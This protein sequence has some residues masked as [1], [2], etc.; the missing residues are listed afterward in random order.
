[1]IRFLNA[2]RSPVGRLWLCM[3]TVVAGC[4]SH[5]ELLEQAPITAPPVARQIETPQ[6]CEPPDQGALSATLPF[7]VDVDNPPN[8]TEW[9]LTLDEVVQITLANSDVIRDLGGRVVTAPQAAPTVYDPA[10]QEINPVTGVEAA[11]SAFDAQLS[12]SLFLDRDERAFNNFFI[13]GG[14][15]QLHINNSNFTLELAKRGATGTRYAVRNLTDRTSNNSPANAF[16]S[17]YDTV[18]EA[19]VRHPLL[20]GG[21]LEYNRIAGPNGAPGNF[22]GVLLARIRTD[23]ALADFEA[24]V[25]NLIREV[26]TAYWRLYFAYR[27]LDARLA[28]YEAALSSWRTVQ[29]QLDAGTSDAEREALARANFYQIKAS[30]QNA[31]SGGTQNSGIIGVYS[32]E[33]NL[34]QLMGIPATDGRLIRPADDPS[35][36][37]RIF[38]WQESL[39]LAL[40]R[41]VELRRQRWTIKQ[42]E[43]EL[44]AARNLLL[45]RV[46]LV[47]LYRWRGFGNN[48]FGNRDQFNGSAFQDL[49][50]GSLQGWRMG[51]EYT[52]ALGR[53]Q[54]H[55]AVRAAELALARDRAVL[56]NQELAISNELS[57]QFG[58]ME[59]AFAVTQDNFNRAIAERQRLE[60]A[61]AKYDAGAEILEF[62][63]QAQQNTAIAD[64]D[65]YDN[66]VAYN[67]AVGGMHVSRGTYLNYMGVRLSEGPWSPDAYRSYQKEFRRFE[68]RLDY[69]MMRPVAFSNGVHP[70]VVGNYQTTDAQPAPQNSGDSAASELAP[71]PAEQL[72]MDIPFETTSPWESY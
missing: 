47:G 37:K 56:R 68:P 70:Q 14:A 44:I 48:L 27:T 15:N 51:I 11:L 3:I 17:V 41:R 72:P 23:I 64:S 33:R 52:A 42:R 26:E 16:P 30:V 2:S 13:G 18:M 31:R 35:F 5:G 39:E 50:G 40:S 29:D 28:A 66:L 34:R 65:F 22:N 62:V 25:R 38:D 1:M 8:P 7:T 12:S 24:S 60:K 4:R 63:L 32:A 58:E 10:L 59:R 21:G 57:S 71:S 46:D 69:C 45:A 19:E 55:A 67:L 61:L 36:A 53:R 9:Y 49:W 20:R 54:E 43:N 6:H